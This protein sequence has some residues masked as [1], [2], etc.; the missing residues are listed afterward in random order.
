[1][2]V[3]FVATPAKFLAPSL[4]L[5]VALDACGMPVGLQLVARAGDDDRLL[6]AGR[7]IEEILGTARDRLGTPAPL[8]GG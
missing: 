3:S 8:S 5:P 2:G 6:A 1:M 4:T 7:A